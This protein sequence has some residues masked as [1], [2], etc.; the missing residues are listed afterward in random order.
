MSTADSHPMADWSPDLQRWWN[1]FAVTGE[2]DSQN[3]PVTAQEAH[4][5]LM[6]IQ[7]RQMQEVVQE[8]QTNV[9]ALMAESEDALLPVNLRRTLAV[10]ARCGARN[11]EHFY[12]SKLD[13]RTH[14]QGALPGLPSAMSVP[15]HALEA[16]AHP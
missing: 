5:L 2:V 16:A 10:C 8:L 9:D 3:P 13:G 1:K 14:R 7:L 15:R 6:E 11:L 12:T 4:R